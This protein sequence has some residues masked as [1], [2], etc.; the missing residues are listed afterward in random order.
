MRKKRQVFRASKYLPSRRSTDVFAAALAKPDGF[1]DTSPFIDGGGRWYAMLEWETKPLDLVNWIVQSSSPPTTTGG[2]L[3]ISPRGFTLKK[4]THLQ[5][6]EWLL[7]R[8][9]SVL[10]YVRLIILHGY[11]GIK[12]IQL[13]EA[14]ASCTSKGLFVW[15]FVQITHV[16]CPVRASLHNF[17]NCNVDCLRGMLG[18]MNIM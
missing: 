10:W 18:Y 5:P 2:D 3:R 7:I 13:N 12:G 8:Y 9:L 6:W 16:L 1:L 14:F 15:A 17:S 4:K 11:E